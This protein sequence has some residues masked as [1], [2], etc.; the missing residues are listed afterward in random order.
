MHKEGTISPPLRDGFGSYPEPQQRNRMRMSRRE[1][2]ESSKTHSRKLGKRL[3]LLSV[4]VG[5][6]VALGACSEAGDI[7]ADLGADAGSEIGRAHV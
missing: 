3:A 4:S 2:H 7:G 5:L 6:G 1:F